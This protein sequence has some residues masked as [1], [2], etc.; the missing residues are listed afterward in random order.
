MLFRPYPALTESERF[1]CLFP[2]DPAAVPEAV[3]GLVAR[4]SNGASRL[5]LTAAAGRPLLHVH[6]GND[7]DTYRADTGEGPMAADAALALDVARACGFGQP[8]SAVAIY[9]DQWTVYQGF[10]PHRPL[11]RVQIRRFRRVRRCTYRAGRVKW[12]SGRVEPREACELDWVSAS[13]DLLYGHPTGLGVLG[14]VG[15]VARGR[16]IK[17]GQRPIVI[18][19]VRW[20]P[21]AGSCQPVSRRAVLASRH[22]S[23]R[24]AL[25]PLV[26]RER[27]AINGSRPSVLDRRAAA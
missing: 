22:W 27:H 10:N 8:L 25:R 16:C 20:R 3:N 18:G 5:R 1:A 15:V 23:R 6:H 13:L 11:F 24:R 4:F 2:L 14:C 17:W 21:W 12:C 19:I 9:D 7:I 26:D